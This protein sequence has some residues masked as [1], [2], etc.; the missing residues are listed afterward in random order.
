MLQTFV[1]ERWAN[2]KLIEQLRRNKAAV[3]FALLRFGQLVDR[4]NGAGVN[5]SAEEPALSRAAHLVQQFPVACHIVVFLLPARS[6]PLP[7]HG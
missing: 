4:G 2:F 5:F 6:P 3:D 1:F 7:D